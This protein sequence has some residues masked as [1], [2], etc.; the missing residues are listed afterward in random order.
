VIG[1]QVGYAYTEELSMDSML[2]AA[3]QSFR[4]T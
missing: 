3:R 2:E 1:D 4:V